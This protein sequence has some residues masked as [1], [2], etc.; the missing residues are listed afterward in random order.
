MLLFGTPL[1]VA[2]LA[3]IQPIIASTVFIPPN[4]ATGES[5]GQWKA[6]AGNFDAPKV[7]P[8][9]GTSYDWW[10]F[11]VVSSTPDTAT[12]GLQSLAIVFYTASAHGF[13]PLAG[14]AALGYTSIDLVQ[15]VAAYPNG[16][17]TS[18]WFN[19]TQATVTSCNDGVRGEFLSD[20]GKATFK[21]SADLSSYTVIIDAHEAGMVGT[22]KLHSV[23]LSFLLNLQ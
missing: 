23:S 3:L 21:G 5:I 2:S 14:A 18:G 8:I 22:L 12:G 20:E 4:P 9:N 7:Q 10:Y 19:G 16:T 1:L 11:D 6:K 15:V 13:T 17:T